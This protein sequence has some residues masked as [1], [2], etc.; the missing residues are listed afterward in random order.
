MLIFSSR[1]H[2]VIRYHMDSATAIWSADG[3]NFEAVDA[4]TNEDA[5]KA[6]IDCYPN[7]GNS[8]MLIND[9]RDF[10]EESTRHTVE[11][12]VPAAVRTVEDLCERLGFKYKYKAHDSLLKLKDPHHQIVEVA[13]RQPCDMAGV[14][15]GDIIE[16]IN[17]TELKIGY[18][19]ELEVTN[20][21]KQIIDNVQPNAQDEAVFELQIYRKARNAEV[22]KRRNVHFV[23][24]RF[25]G[26]FYVMVQV[27]KEIKPGEELIAT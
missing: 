18:G 24:M 27:I 17:G 19:N 22:K 16:Q 9:D 13:P 10:V 7:D 25:K 3:T 5:E 23:H 11:L 6:I 20:A 26:W 15:T 1:S 21:L 4:N 14:Q 2:D 8:V 12:N